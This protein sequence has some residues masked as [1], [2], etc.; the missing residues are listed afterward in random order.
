MEI[1]IRITEEA[2]STLTWNDMIALSSGRSG[3]VD[4]AGLIEFV[5]RFMVDSKGEPLPAETAREMLGK[6]KIDEIGQVLDRV[7]AGARDFLS[8]RQNGT[9][10]TSG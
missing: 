3:Y 6:L 8:Q 9:P 4:Y 2:F 10:A 5:P 7:T 1:N